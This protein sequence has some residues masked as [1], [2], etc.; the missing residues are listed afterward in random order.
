M[1]FGNVGIS[2]IDKTPPLNKKFN[3]LRHITMGSL[4]SDD[5]SLDK[6]FVNATQIIED[7]NDTM[8][9]LV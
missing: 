8:I 7:D 5:N 4:E 3:A 1:E 6:E 2:E 9:N